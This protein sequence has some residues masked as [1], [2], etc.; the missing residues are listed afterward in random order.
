MYIY[1]H[2]YIR[3]YAYICVWSTSLPQ[4][5]IRNSGSTGIG[6]IHMCACIRMYMHIYLFVYI[7]MSGLCPCCLLRSE[8][9]AILLDVCTYTKTY[10]QI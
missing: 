1:L 7:D 3:M 4:A 6:C 10:I 9:L 5:S 8:V 2:T